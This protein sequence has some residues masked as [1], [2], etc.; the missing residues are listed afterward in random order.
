MSSLKTELGAGNLILLLLLEFEVVMCKHCD[1]FLQS[2]G[3]I[4]LIL[5]DIFCVCFVYYGESNIWWTVKMIKNDQI[6]N[7]DCRRVFMDS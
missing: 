1:G 4:V 5:S 2:L 7:L 6:I 3:M